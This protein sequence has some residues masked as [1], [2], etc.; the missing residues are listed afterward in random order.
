MA[1]RPRSFDRDTAL[2]AAMERFWRNGYDETTMADLTRSMGITAP[3]LYAAFGD[4]DALFSEAA[5]Y[6]VGIVT[7]QTDRALEQPT[8][9][10]GISELIH[11][12]ADAYTNHANPP[13]CFL[14]SEPRLIQQRRELSERIAARIQR[15]IRDGDVAPE[16]HPGSMADFALAIIEGMS[17]RA[18]DGGSAAE[19]R[20]IADVAL[21]AFAT[22]TP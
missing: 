4:K 17:T 11:L 1:G 16:T 14:L 18:R 7:A 22:Y 19:V 21:S 15:G 20:G 3:S 5:A 9:Y 13:G 6:Y 2:L 10:S 8:A 12:S